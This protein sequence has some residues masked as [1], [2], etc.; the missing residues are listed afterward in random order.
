MKKSEIIILQRRGKTYRMYEKKVRL[1][2]W[3][4]EKMGGVNSEVRI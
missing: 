4:Y 2:R 3:K 1:R